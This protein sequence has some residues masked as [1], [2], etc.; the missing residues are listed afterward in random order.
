MEPIR[1]RA[2]FKCLFGDVL[3]L[4]HGDTCLDESGGTIVLRDGMMVTAFT[5]AFNE[6]GERDD[7]VASGTVEPTPDWLE[8]E[9]SKWVLRIDAKGV[10][11]QSKAGA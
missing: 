9:G 7:H 2:D 1:L 8:C 6:A 5:E 11:S 3:C 10:R 4:S